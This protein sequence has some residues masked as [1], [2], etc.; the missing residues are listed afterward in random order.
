MIA[1]VYARKSTEQ[2]GVGEEAKSVTRQIERATA[3]AEK[4]GWHV[5]PEHIYVDDGISGAEFAN[6]P[7]F[8]RLMNAL[9]PRARFGALIMSEESR[10]GR[11]QIEVAYALKQLTQADVRVWLYLENRERTLDSPTDKLLMSVTAFAD[12]LEREKA[13]QRTADA[14]HRKATAGHVT[15]G[16]VFGYD[17]VEVTSQEGKRERVERRVNEAEAVIVRRI[18]ALCAAG[19]GFD[20]I[21]KMLNGER[22]LAP[23]PRRKERP[24]WW[25]ASSVRE[26]L[27]RP[28]YRGEIVWNKTKK[29]DR[30]GRKTYTARP[31]SEWVRRE[32]P[33]LR[34]VSEELWTDAHARLE[35]LRALYLRANDGK[36]HGRPENGTESKYLFTGLL[37]CGSCGGPMVVVSRARSKW[38][39]MSPRQFAYACWYNRS[40]GESKCKN[41]LWAPMDIADEAVISSLE[42]RLLHPAVVRR[43]FEKAVAALQPSQDATE[44]T[45]KRLRVETAQVEKELTNLTQAIALGGELGALVAKVKERER[46]RASLQAELTALE[47]LRSAGAVDAEQLSA[48]VSERLTDWHGALRREPPVARQILR[49]VLNGRLVFD[50]REDEDGARFYQFSVPAT[51]AR[52][53]DGTAAKRLVAPT[54]PVRC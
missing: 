38:A 50:P 40:R 8:V 39:T 33:E 5:A 18:F 31:E 53:I 54:G 41:N 1:A 19:K 14:L 27:H 42:K 37:T 28:L 6:R 29:R 34:I 43:T 49:K 24:Q 45:A 23:T 17:N 52:L 4:R 12:E 2:N 26:L 15:G 10:L 36:L 13:R 21:A 47:N 16:R 30:W 11:E 35:K 22:A 7:G 3:Y 44:A 46:Q 32:A 51:L 25:A 9:K 48:D 20:T